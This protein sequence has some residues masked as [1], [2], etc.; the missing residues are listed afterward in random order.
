MFSLESDEM[1]TLWPNYS[2]TF[3][4]YLI[5]SN[6][7]PNWATFVKEVFWFDV[8]IRRWRNDCFV[9]KLQ[10]NFHFLWGILKRHIKLNKFCK[11]SFLI[12]FFC[13]ESD[14]MTVKLSLSILLIPKRGTIVFCIV[15]WRTS[16]ML[17]WLAE[18]CLYW[19]VT[20]GRHYSHSCV[21][22][23]LILLYLTLR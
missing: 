22:L 13:L 23:M 12:Q 4:F 17:Y 1:T 19:G 9:T 3:T 11:I 21:M 14:E 10:L 18:R 5:I 7:I 16:T 15:F 20:G 8:Q 6:S 2:L